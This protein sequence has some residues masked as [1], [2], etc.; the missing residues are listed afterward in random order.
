MAVG[1]QPVWCSPQRRLLIA[2]ANSY[3]WHLPRTSAQGEDLLVLIGQFDVDPNRG[4]SLLIEA[5]TAQPENPAFSRLLP[6][7]RCAAAGATRGG[8]FPRLA[9]RS[10]AP[11]NTESPGLRSPFP[12]QARGR[13]ADAGLA[14]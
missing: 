10:L 12:H 9:S 2:F 1:G 3:R 5:W 7:F 14:L 6:L 11:R 4:L 13:R 8:F